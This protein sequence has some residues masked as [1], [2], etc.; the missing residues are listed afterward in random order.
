MM[1]KIEIE[2]GEFPL[3]SCLPDFLGELDPEDRILYFVGSES[4]MESVKGHCNGSEQISFCFLDD[5]IDKSLCFYPDS[6]ENPANIILISHGVGAEYVLRFLQMK[7]V[8]NKI[9][10]DDNLMLIFE[11][12]TTLRAPPVC[13]RTTEDSHSLVSLYDALLAL[14]I[15]CNEIIY[16]FTVA[17]VD[18]W[19]V[20]KN[21]EVDGAS[22]VDNSI[23]LPQLKVCISE[24]KLTAFQKEF[25]DYVP[26]STVLFVGHNRHCALVYYF[27]AYD[28]EGTY[29]RS[30]GS[31]VYLDDDSLK[32]FSRE[33]QLGYIDDIFVPETVSLEDLQNVLTSDIL[34]EIIDQNSLLELFVECQQGNTRE[35]EIELWCDTLNQMTVDVG[36]NFYEVTSELLDPN[37]D[38]LTDIRII[39]ISL[40]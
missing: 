10:F 6:T 7:G 16:E 36:G 20:H 9:R 18:S 12:P 17:K 26:S 31:Y 4:E 25:I 8:E 19:I 1:K 27:L 22:I 13:F 30:H 2:G 35:G 28:C 37:H 14:S 33:E 5:C 21:P 38:G 3:K 11:D 29:R 40:N 23:D 34:W 32:L 15:R 24:K 39:E